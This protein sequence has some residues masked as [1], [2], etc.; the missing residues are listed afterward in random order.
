[1]ASVWSKETLSELKLMGVNQRNFWR[2]LFSDDGTP[3]GTT[4]MATTADDYFIY[5]ASG[6]IYVVEKIKIV[7]EDDGDLPN[8]EFG[9]LG[10]ALTNGITFR[11]VQGDD[12]AYNQFTDF[13][14]GLTLKQ[15]S[16]FVAL[17]ELTY[18]IDIT[19]LSVLVCEIDFRK[20]F[21]FP[22]FLD[23]DNNF[24]LLIK[25]QDDMSN[26][27]RMHVIASGVSKDA[28]V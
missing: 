24:G 15:T 3:T 8:D 26:L 23:G 6:D 1:M 7:V 20:E 12:T 16:D 18:S 27:E 2:Q 21:G 10:A 14:G 4:D 25:T 19:G 11:L 13:L 5:P 22:I 9:A 28:R 17:G